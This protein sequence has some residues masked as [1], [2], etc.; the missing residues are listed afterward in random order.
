MGRAKSKKEKLG[1]LLANAIEKIRSTYVPCGACGNVYKMEKCLRRF[2]NTASFLEEVIG[3][4]GASVVVN[5]LIHRGYYQYNGGLKRNL[6]YIGYYSELEIALDDKP[7]AVVTVDEYVICDK[8]V[9]TLKAYAHI[10]K[11]HDEEV[12]TGYC[13]R[14]PD[15]GC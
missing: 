12:E 14:L 9:L 6:D 8:G 15:V 4:V 7:V 10:S 13:K 1:E 3:R 5:T 2:A 11:F